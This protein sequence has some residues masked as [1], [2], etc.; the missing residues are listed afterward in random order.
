MVSFADSVYN[1][2]MTTIVCVCAAD[3]SST[4]N[5]QGNESSVCSVGDRVIN[6]Y[7]A[8]QLYDVRIQLPWLLQSKQHTHQLSKLL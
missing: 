3:Y 5:N 2:T 4:T 1:D 8:N 7:K 6:I